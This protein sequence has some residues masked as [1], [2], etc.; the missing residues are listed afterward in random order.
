MTT[1]SNASFVAT[2]DRLHEL[3]AAD[4]ARA[5]PDCPGWDARRLIGHMGSVFAMVANLVAERA[6]AFVPPRDDQKDPGGSA[7]FDWYRVRRSELLEALA[8]RRDGDVQWSWTDDHTV[9]FLRRRMIFESAVHLADLERASGVVPT[10]E[11]SVAVDGI[12]EFYGLMAPAAVGRGRAVPSGS[13]HL[14]CTD[15]PGE[16]SIRPENGSML[17]SHEHSKCDVA[18]RGP[19]VSLFLRAWGRKVDDV[20]VFG[21]TA[22]SAEWTRVA[23]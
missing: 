6:T 8:T 7:T 16:W 18:W 2:T 1:Q 12:D 4:P 10:I 15:G 9:G 5:I 19:A 20:E 11:R 22:V 3:A 14:H 13:L 23:M 17:M 21:S